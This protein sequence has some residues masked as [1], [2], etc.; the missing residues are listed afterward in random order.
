[1]SKVGEW[2]NSRR[3]SNCIKE[4]FDFRDSCD[5][6]DRETGLVVGRFYPYG[7]YKIHSFLDTD[8][9]S[10]GRRS[11]A[12]VS[13]IRNF[14]AMNASVDG[15]DMLARQYV[16]IVSDDC[17]FNV[18]DTEI[19]NALAIALENSLGSYKDGLVKAYFTFNGRVDTDIMRRVIGTYSGQ[20]S[21]VQSVMKLVGTVEFQKES[22]MFIT[23]A[24]TAKNSN[25]VYPQGL[26]LSTVKKHWYVVDE[27]VTSYNLS[28]FFCDSNNDLRAMDSLCLIEESYNKGNRSKMAIHKDTG[29]SRV[30]I[31]KYWNQL[32]K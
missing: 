15:I 13:A 10:S 16:R 24:S 27:D 4:G 21:V 19:D 5:T 11:S 32:T 30:T 3:L 12:L 14:I 9:M 1:M 26:S 2:L 6:V 20:I 22:K 25:K 31:D 17:G 8:E 23:R 28:N 7:Y 29:I 18:S